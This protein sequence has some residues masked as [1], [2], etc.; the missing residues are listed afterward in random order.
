MGDVINFVDEACRVLGMKAAKELEAT[1]T[2][3]VNA[4]LGTFTY[5]ELSGRC[6]TVLLPNGVERWYLD[7]LPL[8]EL[9]P[10]T[11]DRQGNVLHYDRQIKLFDQ[12]LYRSAPSGP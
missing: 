8:V 7:G 2:A 1:L 12:S 5:D 4:R 10:A 11:F 9:S 3:Q 6:M